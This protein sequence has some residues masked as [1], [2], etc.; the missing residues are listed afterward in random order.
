MQMGFPNTN[1][2]HPIV[3][4][5]LLLQSQVLGLRVSQIFC[6]PPYIN[7]WLL[8]AHAMHPDL[9]NLALC[10]HASTAYWLVSSMECSFSLPHPHAVSLSHLNVPI[11]SLMLLMQDPSKLKDFPECLVDNMAT[12]AIFL[13]YIIYRYM[14]IS[15]CCICQVL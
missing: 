1:H 9:L 4:Q 15:V 3:R 11:Y 6:C 8:Q 13:R 5:Y 12:F 10:F 2:S 7:E 14:S